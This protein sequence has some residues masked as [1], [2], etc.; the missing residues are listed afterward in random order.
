MSP[1]TLGCKDYSHFR[2]QRTRKALSAKLAGFLKIYIAIALDSHKYGVYDLQSR[3]NSEG[4][5]S[6]S[7]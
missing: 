2:C 1:I 5:N 7:T 4:R 6:K 3:V